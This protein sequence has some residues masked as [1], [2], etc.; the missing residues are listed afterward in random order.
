MRQH[1]T[2]KEER[3]MRKKG[4]TVSFDAMVKFFIQNYNIPTKKDFERLQNRLDRIEHLLKLDAA[5]GSTPVAL[6]GSD[7][8]APLTALDTVYAIVKRSRNGTT[9]KEI[10]AKTGYGDKKIRNVIFRLNKMGKIERK[11]RGVYISS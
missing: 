5:R 6:K 4:K 3:M 7:K 2:G 9:F 10:Q 11:H 8:K 1:L